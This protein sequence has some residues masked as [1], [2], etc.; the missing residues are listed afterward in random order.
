MNR[1]VFFF[2]QLKISNEMAKCGG[3][4]DNVHF[5][6][7]I[8]VNTLSFSLNECCYILIQVFKSVGYGI[9]L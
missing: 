1:N 2:R 3:P 6:I 7:D 5:I 4:G 9:R 8:H